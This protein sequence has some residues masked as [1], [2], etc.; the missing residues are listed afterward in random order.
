MSAGRNNRKELKK[1]L[2]KSHGPDF[3]DEYDRLVQEEW[4][5]KHL[6]CWTLADILLKG[7]VVSTT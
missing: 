2:K 4:D 5:K 1:K 6:F 7:E 3:K